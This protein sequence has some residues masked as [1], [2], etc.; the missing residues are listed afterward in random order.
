MQVLKKQVERL[1]QGADKDE[2]YQ[3]LLKDYDDL[4]LLT[5][6]QSCKEKPLKVAIKACGHAFCRPCLGKY[7]DGRN[8]ICPTCKNKYGGTDKDIINLYLD[9]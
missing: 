7:Q 9:F 4:L 5:K 8:R 3:E 2:R 1:R 6:C